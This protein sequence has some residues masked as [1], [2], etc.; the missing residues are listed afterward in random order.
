MSLQLDE[1]VKKLSGLEEAILM[2]LLDR[3]Q[4]AF[5]EE[6]YVPEHSGFAPSETLS[7]LE[8]RLLHQ[9]SMDALFGRYLMPEERP[10]YAGLPGSKRSVPA[11]DPEIQI[12]SLETINLS[13]KILISYLDF[14]PQIC[15]KGDDGQY[16][17]SVEHDVIC[18]QAIARRV[19]Y[20]ACYVA[21]SKY[22]DRPQEFK[23]L[24]Q[25]QD[26]DGLLKKL[27]RPEVESEVLKRV[28]RKLVGIQK[29]SDPKTRFLVDEE[30]MLFY[31][32][33]WIIPLTKE[34]EVRYLLQRQL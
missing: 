15:K 6:A 31:F 16:G 8:L 1:V 7:L 17:S 33:D 28:K 32:K 3:C 19:H 20:A 18:L 22:Q 4:F 27:T 34:G 10:F 2:K 12:R 30:F 25:K 13:G 24:I 14:L 5:N 11:R 21:E 29:L 23:E 26:S 9:E